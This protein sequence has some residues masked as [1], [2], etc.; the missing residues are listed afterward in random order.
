METE[1]LPFRL[2][3]FLSSERMDV[4]KNSQI[5]FTQPSALNDP[6]EFKPLF[7]DLFSEDRLKEILDPSKQMIEEVVKNIHLSLSENQRAEISLKALLAIVENNPSILEEYNRVAI[8]QLNEAHRM[9]SD[10]AKEKMYDSLNKAIGILSL[11]ERPDNELMWAHYAES[12][13]GFAIEFDSTHEYFNRRRSN[14]DECFHLRKVMYVD[15]TDELVT[16]DNMDADSFFISKSS[17]WSYE[18]EWRML[19]PLASADKKIQAE[20]DIFLFNIPLSAITSVI[21]GAKSSVHFHS[22]LKKTL[23]GTH[24]IIKK[25]QLTNGH[26]R[27]T[28]PTM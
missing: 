16:F 14:V 28:I 9:L 17:A 7:R 25:A 23:D 2:Y 24:I 13:K 11:T 20:E 4:L 5:R 12:H 22:E 8:P 6:F 21:I 15:R 18:S 1:R 10:L 19:V 3:K 27:V 26:P